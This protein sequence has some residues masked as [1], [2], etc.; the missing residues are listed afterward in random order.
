MQSL[1]SEKLGLAV[2]KISYLG[3]H[4]PWWMV[5]MSGASARKLRAGG[6][7]SWVLA[8]LICEMGMTILTYLIAQLWELINVYKGRGAPQMKGY[9]EVQSIITVI[10]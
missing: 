2:W 10:T 9:A 3:G 4:H 8:V 7:P 5:A 6:P 1:H